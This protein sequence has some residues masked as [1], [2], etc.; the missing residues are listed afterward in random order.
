MPFKEKAAK[1]TLLHDD[2]VHYNMIVHKSHN[3]FTIRDN[4]EEHHKNT[5][6]ETTIFGDVLQS[7]N[8]PGTKSWAQ[9]TEKIRPESQSPESLIK[10]TNL[11]PSNKPV[12]HE[13]RLDTA[14]VDN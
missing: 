9:I 2:D 14:N 11:V 1:L 10:K 12:I 5:H 8:S 6:S 4:I 7:Q 3:A 13:R